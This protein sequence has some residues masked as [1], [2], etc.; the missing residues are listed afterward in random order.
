VKTVTRKGIYGVPWKR[1]FKD[2]RSEIQDDNLVNGAAALGYYLMLAIFP[3]M[4]FLLGLLPYLPVARI[5]QEVL[6][7]LNQILPGDAAEAFTG[8]VRSV[9]SEKRGSVLS[10]S[11]LITL[12]AASNGMSAVMHQLNITYDVKEARPYWKFKGTALLLVLFFGALMIGAFSLVLFGETA[13][14][15]LSGAIGLDRPLSA[16][17]TAL[18]W[19]VIALAFMTAFAVT[20]YFG[21][22]VDQEFRFVTPGSVLGVLLLSAASMGFKF[23]VD[24]F[25][26]YN[27]TYGSIGAVIVLM[28]WLNITGLVILLGSEINA[29]VE[30]YSPGE[31]SKGRSKK[32]PW[33]L[34]VLRFELNRR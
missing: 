9:V 32:M 30:H 18:R 34:R 20:Y 33:R 6:G 23:Y 11:A 7:L 25:G 22:D 10:F 14:T 19:V 26:K 27:A 15:W 31:N 28:L 3:A 2:L 12:W 29:L 16:V 17:F 4:I 1:F 21:P 13:Q 24:N 5:D 8:T